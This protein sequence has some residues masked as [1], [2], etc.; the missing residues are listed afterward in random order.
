MDARARVDARR[1]R[2]ALEVR[3]SGAYAQGR[4]PAGSQG[5]VRAGWWRPCARET[6]ADTSRPGRDHGVRPNAVMSTATLVPETRELD[7]EDASEVLRRTGRRRLLA[8]AFI[9]LR[10]ADGFSHARSLAFM[11]SL[12]L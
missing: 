10:V 4:C 3:Q 9:R 8:D 7:G 2:H 11:T 1:P 12:V 5:R 6:T